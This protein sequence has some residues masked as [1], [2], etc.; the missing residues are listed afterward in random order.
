MKI[1]ESKIKTKASKIRTKAQPKIS[2]ANAMLKTM[3]L[4]TYAV[5]SSII[6][7]TIVHFLPTS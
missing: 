4:I 3:K 6:T 2:M 5:T 7:P 1:S